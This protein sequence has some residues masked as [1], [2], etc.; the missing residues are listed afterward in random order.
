MNLTTSLWIGGGIVVLGLIVCVS[1]ILYAKSRK[2]RAIQHYERIRDELTLRNEKIEEEEEIDED[3]TGGIIGN[4]SIGHLLGGFVAIILGVSLIKPLI[5]QV[6]LVR[7]QNSS[8]NQTL[9]N[10]INNTTTTDVNITGAAS[11]ILELVPLFF[12]LGIF[13]AAIA[14]VTGALRDAGILE[15]KVEK[16]KYKHGIDHYKDVRDKLSTRRKKDEE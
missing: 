1:I 4:L 6:N 10:A 12:A 3:A 2:S 9:L 15:E 14:I 8:V 7:G 16:I 5:D 11:T 13:F